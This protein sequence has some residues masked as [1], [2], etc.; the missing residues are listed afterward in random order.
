M[1]D[2]AR[3]PF[4]MV[5]AV[6]GAL[7]AAGCARQADWYPIETAA[8]GSDGR[9]ITAEIVTGKPGSDGKFCEEVTGTEVSES[10]KQVVLGIKARNN[11]EPLFPWEHGIDSTYIGYGRR[12][13][14]HLK[15]PLAGR[16]LLDQ[17]TQQ[18]VPIF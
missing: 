17:A 16:Q 10:A 8:V 3:F 9:T 1:V 7:L 2:R 15:S 4:R 13:Q 18:G 11:C 5:V 14:F 12:Y 6:I